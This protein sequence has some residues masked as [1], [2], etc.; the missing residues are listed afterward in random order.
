MRQTSARKLTMIIAVLVMI[1]IIGLVKQ[2]TVGAQADD[3]M[4]TSSQQNMAADEQPK[5]N[6][7]FLNKT[8]IPLDTDHAEKQQANKLLV[9]VIDVIKQTQQP[10]IMGFGEV[11]ARWTSSLTAEI[12]GRVDEVSDKLLVGSQ[13]KKGDVLAKINAVD[14]ESDLAQAKSSLA[15]AKVSYLEQQQ[16][17]EQ[18]KNRWA[19]SGLSGEPSLLAL[20]TPQL[21]E[22]LAAFNSAKA[23]LVKAEKN[24]SRTR[25]VAPFNGRVSSRA[26]NPGEY[27]SA[28]TAIGDVFAI[29]IVDIDISLNA[30]Q[31]AL[32][33]NES[34]MINQVVEVVDTANNDAKWTAKIA[35][36]EY[37]INKAE[38]TRNLVLEVDAKQAKTTIMQGTFVQATIPG[39]AIDNLLK[40]PASSLSRTGSIWYVDEGVLQKFKADIIYKKDDYLAVVAPNNS[41]TFQ[42]V[43]Y[44]QQAFIAGQMV[45]IEVVFEPSLSDVMPDATVAIIGSEGI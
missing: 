16:E 15:T 41:S 34:E 10:L 33:G 37:H 44:P 40:L 5:S 19:L 36:F 42:I 20:Q 38:R 4:T 21:E 2:F 11:S 6:D 25:I 8:A 23:S 28:G 18:A 39:K 43:R 35:R 24:V 9:T 22:A 29:D 1:I 45:E 26:I 13:F 7:V 31:F 32:M 17:T 14:Y 30:Q 12:S 27:V 3:I